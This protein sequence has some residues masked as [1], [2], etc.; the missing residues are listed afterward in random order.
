MIWLNEVLCE[1]KGGI[2]NIGDATV[3][4]LEVP[5]DINLILDF[6]ARFNSC[7]PWKFTLTF[8]SLQFWIACDVLQLLNTYFLIVI[9]GSRWS[10]LSLGEI[11]VNA[12]I[13]L[14]GSIEDA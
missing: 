13:S 6:F 3:D 1:R 11:H 7:V 8:V 14:N 4:I 9:F 5:F 12:F 2:G 10:F